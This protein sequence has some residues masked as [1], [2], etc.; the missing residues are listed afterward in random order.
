MIKTQEVPT[1]H[2]RDHQAFLDLQEA[3]V[4]GTI[5]PGSR[6]NEA[7]LGEEYG[8]SRGPVRE[9]I[10]RLEERQL[11]TRTPYAGV[12]V[13]AMT[14]QDIREM[15]EVRCMLESRAAM[16]AAQHMSEENIVHLGHI[17]GQHKN[18][19]GKNK[20]TSYYQAAGDMDFHYQ[21]VQGCGNACL[22][23]IYEKELYHRIRMVRYQ[24]SK[25]RGRPSLAVV[26]HEN[27]FDALQKRDGELAEFLMRRHIQSAITNLDH[28]HLEDVE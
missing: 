14:V 17:L 19:I 10:R 9:A 26:E 24:L 11:L 27:I 25:V 6:I 22:L 4:C 23:N 12:R 16:L 28:I 15:Y 13:C 18:Q 20:G 2:T 7:S 3:I 5:K 21:V 1:S 8:M